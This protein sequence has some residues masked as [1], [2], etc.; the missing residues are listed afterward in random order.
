MVKNLPARRRHELDPWIGK[1]PW[2][3]KWEPILVFLPAKFLGI[4]RSRRLVVTVHGVKE[5]D[6]T[7]RVRTTVDIKMCL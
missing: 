1:I 3:R 4:F 6:M 2:R 5:S 7:E